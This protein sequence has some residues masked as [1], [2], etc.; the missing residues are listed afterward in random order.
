MFKESGDEGE[1]VPGETVEDVLDE[2]LGEDDHLLDDEGIDALLEV[3]GVGSSSSSTDARPSTPPSSSD[4]PLKDAVTPQKRHQEAMMLMMQGKRHMLVKDLHSAVNAYQEACRIM[5]ETHGQLAAPCGDAYMQYGQAL[6]ELARSENQVLGMAGAPA[7]EDEEEEEDDEDDDEEQGEEA[8]KEEEEEEEEELPDEDLEAS[9]KE[10]IEGPSSRAKSKDKGKGLAVKKKTTTTT[11]LP[12]DSVPAKKSSG[13]DDEEEEEEENENPDEE[14]VTNLQLAWEMVELAKLVFLKS[15]ESKE[16]QIK[17]A[18]CFLTLGEVSLE[19]EAYDAAVDDFN[20]CLEIQRKNLP[21]D[22]RYIAETHY[23]LGLTHSFSK[24]YSE[25]RLHFRHAIKVLESRVHNCKG[26][27]DAA[28]KETGSRENALKDEKVYKAKEEIEDLKGLLPEI[29]AKYEDAAEMEAEHSEASK[30]VKEA[31]ENLH[32]SP[33]KKQPGSAGLS[34]GAGSSGINGVGSSS[35]GAS[36]SSSGAAGSSSGASTS[37]SGNALS[38][39]F[40]APFPRAEDEKAGGSSSSSNGVK[41]IT[42]GSASSASTAAPSGVSMIAVRRNLGKEP[43]SAP[44]SSSSSSAFSS[45]SSSSSVPSGAVNDIS[46]LVRRKRKPEEESATPTTHSIS[47]ASASAPEASLPASTNGS[48]AAA[49][50]SEVEAAPVPNG[51]HAG[52]SEEIDGVKNG[53]ETPEAKRIKID[54]DV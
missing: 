52:K 7:E 17:A 4:Q 53:S 41:K 10:E 54:G 12:P 43:S 35:G 8:S 48:E 30:A 42:F 38:S 32:R 16:K 46:S 22:D 25:A 39:R 24:N 31:S 37:T 27:L 18:D 15:P 28:I 51:D 14:E 44:A 3:N 9:A 40:T 45:S 1:T 6:L 19:S 36:G 5:D 33:T 34:N 21:E 2:Q 11:M 13:D 49:A 26:V 50:S 47:A 20:K 23:Q 29:L